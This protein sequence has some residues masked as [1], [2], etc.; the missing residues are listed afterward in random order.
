[1]ITTILGWLISSKAR[2]ILAATVL[3]F[4]AVAWASAVDGRVE[5]VSSKDPNVRKH[6]DYSGVVIWL[7]P[8]SGP[9]PQAARS[10]RAEMIQKE[11]T[12]SARARHHRGDYRKLSE[13]RSDLS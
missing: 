8:I 4:S 6:R 3:L 10:A 2:F 13:L 1:M 11:K 7:E 9:A 12:F 5:L